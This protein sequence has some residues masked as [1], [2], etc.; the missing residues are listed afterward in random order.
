MQHIARG[1]ADSECQ[2]VLSLLAKEERKFVSIILCP[3]SVGEIIS[4]IQS[5]IQNTL[6]Q[7]KL[8]E[9]QHKLYHAKGYTNIPT[10][11]LGKISCGYYFLFMKRSCAIIDSN[12]GKHFKAS[13]T[14][15]LKYYNFSNY[16]YN[17]ECILI[18]ARLVTKIPHP[19]YMAKDGNIVVKARDSYV[20]KV[21][22]N[23]NFITQLY[24]VILKQ[25]W[26]RFKYVERW[27]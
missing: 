20:L 16:N 2:G 19:V 6:V 26:F 9:F 18:D 8:I 4:L 25:N 27:T 22:A 10:S 21:Q 15:W 24:I 14:K 17:I 13:C 23:L 3:V 1:K 12:K 7:E 11:S 5:L